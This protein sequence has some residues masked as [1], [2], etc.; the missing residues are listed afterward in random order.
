MSK[1]TKIKTKTEPKLI[2]ATLLS[3]TEMEALRKMVADDAK[4]FNQ[5]IAGL[6]RTL[7]LAEIK[8][9]NQ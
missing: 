2:A 5:T 9:R 6:L 3:V 8:R 4:T 1:K 7:L